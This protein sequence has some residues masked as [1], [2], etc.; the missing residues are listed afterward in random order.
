MVN[1]LDNRIVY[2]VIVGV[3]LSAIGIALRV[4]ANQEGLQLILFFIT[5]F[6]V[7]IVATGVKRGFLLSVVLSILYGIANIAVVSPE[8][9][10]S[11]CCRR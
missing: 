1:A 6:F 4:F 10:P 3:V 9:F 7:G 5:A 8:N 11:G 2:A